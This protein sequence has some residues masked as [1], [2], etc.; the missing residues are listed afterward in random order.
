MDRAVFISFCSG[1]HGDM[2][3]T[4]DILTVSA[5]LILL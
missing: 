2:K 5:S 4:N 3:I 1:F